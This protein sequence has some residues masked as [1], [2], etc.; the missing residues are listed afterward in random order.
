MENLCNS[1][2]RGKFGDISTMERFELFLRRY[3]VI[4]THV[5]RLDL[6][7]GIHN[8]FYSIFLCVLLKFLRSTRIWVKDIKYL[9][10]FC[11]SMSFWAH[12]LVTK[13]NT[14]AS[15]SFWLPL[16]CNENKSF[17]LKNEDKCFILIEIILHWFLF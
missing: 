5:V 8:V 3:L 10:S 12:S 13:T 15:E 11:I 7:K 1:V 14:S 2:S 16:L 17:A 9:M 4:L 6:R